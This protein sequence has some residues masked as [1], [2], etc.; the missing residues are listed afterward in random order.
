MAITF[1]RPLPDIDHD[2]WVKIDFMIDDPVKTSASGARLINYTQ[3]EDAIWVADIETKPLDENEFSAFDAW[4]LSLR[5]G[6]RSVL[7]RHPTEGYPKAHRGNHSPADDPGNLVSVTDGNVLSVNSVDA[8]LLLSVGDRIGLEQAGRY[9]IGRITEV[10][11]AGTTR[12]ITV[13][14]PPFDTVA[15]AGAVV[16][17]ANPALVMRLVPGS[18][19]APGEGLFRTISFQLRESQ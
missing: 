11:G 6:L 16:R 15:Q 10:S 14:P 19:Q 1:P 12:S 9:Y 5:S 7:F 4:N 13:E 3:T 2:D 17:F 18:F 8:G